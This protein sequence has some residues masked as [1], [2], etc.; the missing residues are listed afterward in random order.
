MSSRSRWTYED[1]CEQLAEA[2]V[3]L[4]RTR[5][6]N[7][8]FQELLAAREWDRSFEF[9]VKIRGDSPGLILGVLRL[10]RK[11]QGAGLPQLLSERLDGG[12][13]C[14]SVRALFYAD[15]LAAIERCLV[16]GRLSPWDVV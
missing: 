6:A 2:R 11:H 7:Q 4:A 1:Q 8:Y 13:V 12:V 3:E 16:S 15:A 10:E 5:A 14:V 9:G